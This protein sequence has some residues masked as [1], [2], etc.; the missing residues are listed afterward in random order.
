MGKT[1]GK[2]MGN[3]LNIPRSSGYNS[4]NMGFLGDSFR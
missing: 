2:T 3:V 1:V 4:L